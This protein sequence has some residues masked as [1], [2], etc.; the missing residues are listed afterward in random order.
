MNWQHIEPPAA[1]SVD[2]SEINPGEAL[3]RTLQLGHFLSAGNHL[4]NDQ[5]NAPSQLDVIGG[6]PHIRDMGRFGHALTG[7]EAAGNELGIG[8][9]VFQSSVP[10]CAFGFRLLGFDPHP[11]PKNRREYL[12]TFLTPEG[13][14]LG[15]FTRWPAGGMTRQ[16]FRPKTDAAPFRAIRI[17]EVTGAGFGVTSIRAEP[18]STQV[19]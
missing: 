10:L 1:L 4:S 12:F 3:E 9:L 2:F 8:P 16:G 15:Q 13:A 17:E 5:A 7:R 19:S 11:Q 18:C 6:G 14:I